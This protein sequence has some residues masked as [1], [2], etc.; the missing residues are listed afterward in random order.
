VKKVHLL[1]SGIFV[2]LA[3]FWL[4]LMG[5]SSTG[6]SSNTD[7]VAPKMIRSP[8]RIPPELVPY[9]PR[10]VGL[11]Q[12][13]GFAVGRTEDPQALELVLEFNGNPFNLRV[14]VGL[15]REGIPVLSASATNSGWGTALARGSAV[16][17][18]ANS[19]A[20]KFEAELEKLMT[21]T[22]ILQN[23]DQ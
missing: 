21:R 23:A 1:R 12:Q 18:L 6:Y 17:S 22:E 5:C 11:L 20:S 8:A 10:F 7:L 3:L 13:S 19:A 14:S 9:V 2:L 15:W 16:N 4:S